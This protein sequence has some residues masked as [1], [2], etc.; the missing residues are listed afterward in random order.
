MEIY[1][2]ILSSSDTTTKLNPHFI[3]RVLRITLRKKKIIFNSDLCKSLKTIFQS[4]LELLIAH[5]TIEHW[6]Y[7][8]GFAGRTDELA[9]LD[10]SLFRERS[11]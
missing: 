11:S 10:M 8:F 3:R 9:I 2:K 7:N 1:F 4:I 6:L 5:H